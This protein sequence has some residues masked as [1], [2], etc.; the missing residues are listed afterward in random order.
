[1][2]F[3]K[4]E[5]WKGNKLGRPK[6]V[7]NRSSEEMKLTIARAV[8]EGLD[9]LKSDLQRIRKE[10]PE[11]ALNII[12]KLL[13]YNIPKLKAVDMNVRGEITNKIESI[14]VNINQKNIDG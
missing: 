12:L 11:K 13:D 6:G 14:T 7:P 8:N 10:D 1:M 3:I 5:N 4:G 9:Y 2:P